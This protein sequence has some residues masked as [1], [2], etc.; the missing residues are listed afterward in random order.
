MPGVTV[1][2]WMLLLNL[3]SHAFTKQHESRAMV[4]VVDSV[5]QRSTYNHVSHS[6]TLFCHRQHF[7]LRIA[8]LWLAHSTLLPDSVR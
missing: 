4:V 6:A 2:V 7:K 5:L 1:I 8:L 3:S